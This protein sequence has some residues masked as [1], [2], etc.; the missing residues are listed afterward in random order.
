MGRFHA[1]KKEGGRSIHKGE[2]KEKKKVAE[3][4]DPVNRFGKERVV[5]G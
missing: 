2:R 3:N 4:K 5:W 1:P